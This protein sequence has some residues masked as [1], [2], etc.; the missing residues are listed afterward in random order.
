MDAHAAS[1]SS[2]LI[3]CMARLLKPVLVDFPMENASNQV[4]RLRLLDA[5]THE[6]VLGRKIGQG[7]FAAVYELGPDAVIKIPHALKVSPGR[8]PG[9]RRRAVD[10]EPAELLALQQALP[11]IEADPLFPRDSSW[12][13]GHPS[14]AAILETIE[15]D[16]GTLLVKPKL[17]GARPRTLNP[18]QEHSLLELFTLSGLI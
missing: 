4:P 11:A 18:E 6:V 17:R 7:Y 13:P 15:A 12:E 1:S 2:N 14:A 10:R 3:A 16:R 5:T 8:P 9:L